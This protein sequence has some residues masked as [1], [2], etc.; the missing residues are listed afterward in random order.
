VSGVLPWV[1]ALSLGAQ[2]A[3]GPLLD[4]SSLVPSAH[5]VAR[6]GGSVCEGREDD[7]LGVAVVI[8]GRRP[9]RSRWGHI[10]LRFLACEGGALRDVEFETS[11]VDRTTR[12]WLAAAFP[13]EDW[14][15]AEDFESLQRDR[16]ILFRN[17][18][19]VDAGDYFEQLERNR[20]I[21][22]LWTPWRGARAAEVL[23]S[24][25][26]DYSDQLAA[27]RAGEV[28]P[29]DRYRPLSTNC[30]QPVR[31][32]AAALGGVGGVDSVFP[33]RWRR[34]LVEQAG[35]TVVV[36]PSADVLARLEAAEGDLKGAW[37]GAAVPLPRP[38]LRRR[39]PEDRM[40]AYRAR[41][42]DEAEAVGVR[43]V[44]PS[45]GN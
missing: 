27:F 12:P 44:V 31:E 34:A 33:F 36:H 3:D 13:E 16:L 2:L 14:H 37:S 42:L 9:G 38:L 6:T 26:A 19:P 28:V 18:D 43:V 23:A 21:V 30:T 25:E 17:E 32:A 4:V 15:L 45:P 40:E 35:V 39:L 5:P 1:A 7:V 20:E 29:R 24:L 41:I 10:S 22:E 11:R 8:Y